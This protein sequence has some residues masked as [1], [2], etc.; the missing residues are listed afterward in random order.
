M[1]KLSNPINVPGIWTS[2][3]ACL[4]AISDYFK[5]EHTTA[6]IFGCTGH[7][8]ILNISA[9]MC[10]SGPT[11]FSDKPM[12]ALC[13]NM[14]ISLYGT[15]FDRHDPDFAKKQKEAWEMTR[16]AID[17]DMP[18]IGWELGIPEYNIIYGYDEE[19]YLY[20]DVHGKP[21]AKKWDTLGNT[22]I[23]VVSLF[24]ANQEDTIADIN[25]TL[26]DA[27]TFALQFSKHKKEWTYPLYSNGIKGY[28]VWINALQSDNL[29]PFGL[30]YNTA[31]WSE[32]RTMAHE[33]LKETAKKLETHMLDN[34][35]EHYD[36]VS[37]SLQKVA[38]LFPMP[39]QPKEYDAETIES[40]IDNLFLAKEAEKAAFEEM[41]QLITQL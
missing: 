15:I 4:K 1:K 17:N 9:D 22:E 25:K 8:F 5:L 29:N 32:C 26:K 6:W 20:Y 41:K 11:A 24:S 7:A 3:I 40:A 27:F 13:K 39:P 31:V 21:Q 10:P 16:M 30:A 33:F 34:L 23:G 38:R 18:T 14:G 36:V 12:A 35:I 37:W 19:N 28:D 2:Y